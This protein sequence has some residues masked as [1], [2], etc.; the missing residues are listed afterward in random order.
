[1]SRVKN[2]EAPPLTPTPVWESWV[3]WGMDS[4]VPEGTRTIV[5][6]DLD[7]EVKEK[8]VGG[9]TDSK[10]RA[11][12]FSLSTVKHDLVERSDLQIQAQPERTKAASDQDDMSSWNLFPLYGEC[13]D[14]CCCAS[15][16]AQHPFQFFS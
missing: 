16:L 3:P 12:V 6:A 15:H 11:I 10:R 8:E 9:T 14:I 5:D 1:M 4:P 13:R 2:R 7:G